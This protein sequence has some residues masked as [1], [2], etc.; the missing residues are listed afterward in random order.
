MQSQRNNRIRQDR[1]GKLK[2]LSFGERTT[3][4]VLVLTILG[5]SFGFLSKFYFSFFTYTFESA[6]YLEL[7]L[8]TSHI[9]LVCI[10]S[11]ISII[12]FRI[13]AYI[14]AEFQSLNRLKIKSSYNQEK[15][16]QANINYG[17]ILNDLSVNLVIGAIIVNA[18][19]IIQSF[20]FEDKILIGFFIVI[21]IF[22]LIFVIVIFKK[23]GFNLNGFFKKFKKIV[24]KV[25]IKKIGVFIMVASFWLFLGTNFMMS[26]TITT[27]KFEGSELNINSTFEAPEN[28]VITFIHEQDDKQEVIK[29][30]NLE[31]EDFKVAFQESLSTLNNKN[32]FLEKIRNTKS[33]SSRSLDMDNTNYNYKYRTDYKK[34]L[35]A[36]QNYVMIEFHIDSLESKNSKIV[37]PIYYENNSLSIQQSEFV[38]K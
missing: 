25:P 22:L 20:Y 16:D 23:F 1:E 8:R 7:V 11:Y 17:K 29:T 31:S 15:V 4:L 5:G 37:N 24:V 21:A 13:L 38:F 6:I 19:W 14:F 3:R 9:L 18:Y 33:D 2:E 32:D 12:A 34:Y 26:P 35:K 28:V 27:L 36:G 10:G 30:I